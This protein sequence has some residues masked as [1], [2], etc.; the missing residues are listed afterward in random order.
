[1]L[2]KWAFGADKAFLLMLVGHRSFLNSNGIMQNM[3]YAIHCLFE[4][5]SNS[6]VLKVLYYVCILTT[7]TGELLLGQ[8][9]EIQ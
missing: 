9:L 3:L 4:S 6:N 7:E 8:S 2:W 1:M 5:H